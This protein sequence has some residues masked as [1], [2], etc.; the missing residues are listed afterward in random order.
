MMLLYFNAV[1]KERLKQEIL[2]QKD[3]QLQ[4]LATYSQ[5]VRNALW[6]M[7]GAFRVMITWIF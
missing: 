1:S 5:H 4:E 3:R 6:E 7:L 2:E